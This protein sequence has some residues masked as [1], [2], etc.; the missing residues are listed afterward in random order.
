MDLGEREVS[1]AGRKGG[2]GGCGQNVLYERRRKK[3]K[4][5][6]KQ[7]KQASLH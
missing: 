4:K 3:K 6:I 7:C 5:M 2:R 1:G